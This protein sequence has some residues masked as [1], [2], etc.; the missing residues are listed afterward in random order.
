LH[1]ALEVCRGV[2]NDQKTIFDIEAGP[3]FLGRANRAD[4]IAATWRDFQILWA[5]A[6]PRGTVPLDK[7]F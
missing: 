6:I 2:S 7:E 1:L 4:H 3:A 5:D